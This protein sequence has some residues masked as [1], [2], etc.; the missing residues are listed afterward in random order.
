MAKPS[1]PFDAFLYPKLKDDEFAREYL[2]TCLEDGGFKN[3]LRALREVIEV[4]ELSKTQ[5]STEAGISR[6]NLYHLL[7]EDGNPS[8]KSI[9]SLLKTLGFRFSIDRAIEPPC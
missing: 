1:I 8:L 6:D 4:R 7:S 5:L 2:S 3:F 9:T